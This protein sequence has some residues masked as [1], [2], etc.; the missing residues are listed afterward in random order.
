M[1]TSSQTPVH[2]CSAIPLANT[3]TWKCSCKLLNPE[4]NPIILYF[5]KIILFDIIKPIKDIFSFTF[6]L[7]LCC[8]VIRLITHMITVVIHVTIMTA[9]ELSSISPTVDAIVTAYIT[10]LVHALVLLSWFSAWLIRF[11]M[12]IQ[13]QPLPFHW[14]TMIQSANR[15]QANGFVRKCLL[16]S[17]DEYLPPDII[18]LIHEYVNIESMDDVGECVYL[19]ATLVEVERFQT[20]DLLWVKTRYKMRA[21]LDHVTWFEMF[22]WQLLIIWFRLKCKCWFG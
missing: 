6:I 19:C 13:L 20:M 12:S 2:L 14:M 10:V 15:K 3:I 5:C 1:V 17:F 9:L 18:G 16:K 22:S 7:D 21:K 8:S 11:V 4:S